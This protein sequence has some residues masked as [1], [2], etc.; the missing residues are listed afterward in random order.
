M[1]TKQG[2]K[3]IGIDLGTTN[4]VVAVMEGKEPK[5][6][7]NKEGNRLTPSVVAFNDKGETLVGDIARRQAVTNPKR[8]IYSIKRFMGRRHNEVASEEKIVPYE[9]MGGP[10]DYVKVRAGDKEFTPPEI[11]AKVLRP[12][13][14][15]R[16]PASGHQGRRPDRRPRGDAD[17]QR[18][19]CGGPRLRPGEEEGREDRGV[20]SRWR[21]VRRVGARRFEGR[22][23]P[24]GEHQR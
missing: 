17:R 6:I 11:S 8:T 23:V 18:A 2:E 16:R 21:H 9:V 14:L 15:Q 20:R 1:A 4:S 13:V 3:I 10:D 24:G 7:A 12:G 5:V 19:D 22:R